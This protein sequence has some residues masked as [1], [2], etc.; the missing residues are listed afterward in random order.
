M[1]DYHIYAHYVEENGVSPTS[2]RYSFAENKTKVVSAKEVELQT[3]NT[4]PRK[5]LAFMIGG[6]MKVNQYVGE[7]SENKVSASRR[8]TALSYAAMALFGVTNPLA[9]AVGIA[10]FT[11][12]KVINYQIRNYK[13]NL[14]A[15]FLRSL[16]GGVVTTRG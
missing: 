11:A 12:N 8:Q 16:S 14:S 5:E 10:V 3:G 13:E 7:L 2:P 9:A 15:D 6:A 1:Q 4:L